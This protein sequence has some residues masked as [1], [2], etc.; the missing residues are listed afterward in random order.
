GAWIPEVQRGAGTAFYAALPMFHADGLTL[1]L[2]FA[3]SMAARL[4]LFPKFDPDMVLDVTRKRPATVLPLV[5]PIAERLLTRARERGISLAGTGIGVC[6]AMALDAKLVEPW[7]AATG[8]YL[9]E[10]YGRSECSPVLMV[11]P[12]APNRV[13]GSIGL[14][15]P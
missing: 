2:T 11:N 8:G 1:C 9:V 12:V 5:P 6:G 14:P 3:T 7:E 13:A 4:V 15:I 10:G